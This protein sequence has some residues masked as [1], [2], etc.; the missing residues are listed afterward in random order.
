MKIFLV[1]KL[2]QMHR[3]ERP[4]EVWFKLTH[5]IYQNHHTLVDAGHSSGWGVGTN[6]Y[7]GWGQWGVDVHHLWKD[8]FDNNDNDK[9]DSNERQW[10]WFMVQKNMVDFD[11]LIFPI[12]SNLM[13]F[14]KYHISILFSIKNPALRGV[15]AWNWSGKW[16][17]EGSQSSVLDFWFGNVSNKYKH[18]H[19]D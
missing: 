12:K 14:Q 1:F 5:I 9:Y 10:W 3:C 19:K 13:S 17:G 11:F 16:G 7:E 4:P 8:D 18:C 2:A 15:G 6:W